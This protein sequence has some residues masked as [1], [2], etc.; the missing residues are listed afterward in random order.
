MCAFCKIKS[1]LH[2][3]YE[4]SI[5]G[6]LKAKARSHV[7]QAYNT[8]S[9]Q[10]LMHH[11][12]VQSGH[13]AARVRG[14]W[15]KYSNNHFL[16]FKVLIAI[17]TKPSF[18]SLS[19]NASSEAI[20][21]FAYSS[22]RARVWSNPSLCRTSSRACDLV[23]RCSRYWEMRTYPSNIALLGEFPPHQ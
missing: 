6:L 22:A 9:M 7:T 1:G 8:S 3:N 2:G 20:A 4:K 23:S 12:T 10:I 16:R 11:C 21:R 17:S 13:S 14:G 18:A 5:F 15:Y 19:G